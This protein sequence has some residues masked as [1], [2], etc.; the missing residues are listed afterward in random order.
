MLERERAEAEANSLRRKVGKISI[1]YSSQSFPL[2]LGRDPLFAI[3]NYQIWFYR[4][5][6]SKVILIVQKKSWPR[7]YS[8]LRRRKRHETTPNVTC[9]PSRMRNKQTSTGSTNK[10]RRSRLPNWAQMTLIENLKVSIKS[11]SFETVFVTLFNVR[12]RS[13]ISCRGKRARTGRKPNR[14]PVLR[15]LKTQRGAQDAQ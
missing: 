11:S 5:N 7:R 13:Q 10:N 15:E 12:G 8:T 14:W 6:F 9:D 4:C 3:H 1:L 2:F